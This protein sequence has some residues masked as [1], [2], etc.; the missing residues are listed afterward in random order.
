MFVSAGVAHDLVKTE[1][2]LGKEERQG[3]VLEINSEMKF[4][5]GSSLTH[6]KASTWRRRFK[7]TCPIQPVL[8][9]CSNICSW[10]KDAV[11]CL[12]VYLYLE[13]QSL[14]NFT[15]DVNDRSDTFFSGLYGQQQT[16][17]H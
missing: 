7:L 5:P 15:N 3:T 10:T 17:I 6:S 1:L 16:V 14:G 2:V 9:L 13:L 12:R 4:P 11:S 8:L